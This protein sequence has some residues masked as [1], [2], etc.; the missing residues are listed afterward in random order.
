MLAC[1]M[2]GM[3]WTGSAVMGMAISVASTVVLIRVLADNNVLDTDQGHIA[4][5]WLIVED[6]IT[7]FLL[8]MLPA[9]GTV[10]DVGSEAIGTIV[11]A[12]GMA[13]VKV[14]GLAIVVLW[15]GR[16]VIPRILQQVARTRTRELFTLTILSIA[17]A[18]ATGAAVFFGVSMALGAFLAGMVVGQSAVSHQAAADA[19][20]MRDAF[21]VLF[22]VSVGMQFDASVIAADPLLSLL[23]L[24]VILVAKPLA[25]WGIVWSL[26]Y[27]VRTALTVGIA[28]AQIGE[29]SFILAELAIDLDML[30]PQGE[31]LLVAA[32]ILT[33][34][35]NPLLFRGV[36]PLEGWM[37]RQPRLWRL[38]SRRSE[39]QALKSPGVSVTPPSGPHVRRAIVIGYGPV[40]RTA[41]AILRE[42]GIQPV[43]VDLNV[44]T[45]TNLTAQGELAVF[46][47][48]AQREILN[49]AGIDTAQY[50][51]ITI[52]ELQ[53]RTI[54]ILVARELNPHIKVFV[55]AR[56]L[57]ER[58][59][60]EE[61]GTT[62]V[63]YEEAEAAMGLSTILLREVGAD[64]ERISLELR[65]TRAR[66]A[67]HTLDQDVD[68]FPLST[69]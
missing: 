24:A 8:V 32:A 33:I 3:S 6:L 35:L 46:G 42:F 45:V 55:R 30:T 7:V 9:L 11:A 61:I 36:A 13:L 57:E 12:F 59:W 4:V 67:F 44:D 53:T 17:L 37:R 31:T 39:I 29:F 54:I 20:P 15:G 50:L 49:D 18:I 34:S 43:I 51:L 62:E 47:D 69:T 25:A 41:S 63:C 23:L 48:A 60:L 28:L 21:A 38:L 14:I 58:A 26:G 64:E 2:A 5:G 22:F 52:P 66:L 56:Y 16:I 27:S 65:R 19:L 10:R 1:V 40:G 68:E